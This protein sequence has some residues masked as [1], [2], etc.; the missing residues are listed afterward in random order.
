MPMKISEQR[1]KFLN[2]FLL[3]VVFSLQIATDFSGQ[4]AFRHVP[5]SMIQAFL[6]IS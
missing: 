6:D 2:D 3:R 4:Y 5:K 1:L